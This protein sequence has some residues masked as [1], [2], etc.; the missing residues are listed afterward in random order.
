MPRSM[1]RRSAGVFSSSAAWAFG[2]IVITFPDTLNSSRSPLLRTARLRTAGGTTSGVLFLTVTVMDY[3]TPKGNFLSSVGGLRRVV[4]RLRPPPCAPVPRQRLINF[5]ASGSPRVPTMEPA[6]FQP[7]RHQGCG[8]GSR[9]RA[10][11]RP[12]TN[13]GFSAAVGPGD[14]FGVWQPDSSL[15]HRTAKL[16]LTRIVTCS[17]I[18]KEG[19]Y[20]SSSEGRLMRS[21]LLLCAGTTCVI[22]GLLQLRAQSTDSSELRHRLDEKVPTWIRVFNATGVSIAY[23]EHGKIAWTAY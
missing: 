17:Y 19:W 3:N 6:G 11:F 9:G 15:A 16:R 21:L 14:V 8:P 2:R 18:P 12:S 13:V 1:E 23:I 7:H 20:C 10:I 5:L 4:N 22:S